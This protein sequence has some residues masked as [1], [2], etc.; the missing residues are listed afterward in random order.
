MTSDDQQPDWSVKAV[1]VWRRLS[2]KHSSGSSRSRMG[3]N[4][5]QRN[6][7]KLATMV[8]AVANCYAF[9]ALKEVMGFLQQDRAAG[10]SEIFS[11]DPKVLME[12]VNTIE[13][14]GHL[15]SYIRRFT[16]ARLANIYVGTAANK[17]QL[18]LDD[19]GAYPSPPP[20][21]TKAHKSAAY[22]AM[23]LHIWGLPFPAQK[24]GLKMTRRGLIDSS[25]ADALQWNQY[26]GRLCRQIEAG[27]RWLGLATRFGWSTLGLITREWS[28]GDIKAGASDSL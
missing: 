24:K 16:L 25:A 23:I 27:Q 20:L 8:L 21:G 17:G 13:K 15:N 28:I 4:T 19:D 10:T 2:G 11:N 7:N 3:R 6:V 22:T 9:G 14:T 12:T 5:P 1:R 26:K 18:T